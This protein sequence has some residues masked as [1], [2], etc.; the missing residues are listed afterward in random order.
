MTFVLPS[1]GYSFISGIE[2]AHYLKISMIITKP[3][4]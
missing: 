4:S 3:K 1:V 2:N